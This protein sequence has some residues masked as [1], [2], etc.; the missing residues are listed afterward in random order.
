MLEKKKAN[1]QID[2][3]S[4]LFSL[5]KMFHLLARRAAITNRQTLQ[6]SKSVIRN[7]YYLV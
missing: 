2:A 7:S 1:K 3:I 4:N 6:L 5:D